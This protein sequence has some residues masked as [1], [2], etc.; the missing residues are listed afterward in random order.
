M[1]SCAVTLSVLGQERGEHTGPGTSPSVQVSRR[2]NG[3]A[4]REWRDGSER[5][6]AY[7]KAHVRKSV[8][9]G[10]LRAGEIAS[11]A[12]LGLQSIRRTRGS[13]KGSVVG[14]RAS[15]GRNGQCRVSAALERWTRLPI[16]V[17][18]VS[19]RAGGAQKVEFEYVR[20]KL[21][22]GL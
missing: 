3:G 15:P 14:G 22:R 1:S 5:G 13:V 21:G 18:L 9:V 2:T 20:H 10:M 11:C 6:R 12:R 17:L 7:A 19:V 8:T 4:A 16:S